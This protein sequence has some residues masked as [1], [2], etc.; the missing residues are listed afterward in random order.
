MYR[1]KCCNPMRNKKNSDKKLAP[2]AWLLGDPLASVSRKFTNLNFW[3]VLMPGLFSTRR[4]RSLLTFGITTI[5]KSSPMTAATMGV[6]TTLISGFYLQQSMLAPRG[7]D[8]APAQSK[9][10]IYR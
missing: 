9:P 3:K 1:K 4:I 5:I 2:L 6:I 8:E 7:S 10:P